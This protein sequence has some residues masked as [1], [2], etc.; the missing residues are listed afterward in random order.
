MLLVSEDELSGLVMRL[1]RARIAA[2]YDAAQTT[3]ENRRHWAMA[4][5]LGPDASNSAA[6]RRLLRER[7]RL[8]CANNCYAAGALQSLGND[9]VGTGPRL[10]VR[11]GDRAVARRIEQ[12]FA[13]WARA[14]RLTVKLQTMVKARVRDGEAFGLL[15]NNTRLR[16]E[17]LLDMRL[18]EADMVRA[19]TGR[20]DGPL[21]VDGVEY[22]EAWNPVK[23]WVLDQHPGEAIGQPVAKEYD[24]S[25]VVHTYRE[26][27]PGQS[28]G[29]PELTPA[30]GLF[31]LLRQFILATVRAADHAADYAAVMHTTLPTVEAAEVYGTDTLDIER[32]TVSALPEGWSL[33]QLEARHPNAS[34]R[35]F[36]GEILDEIGRALQMPSNIIRGNSAGYNYASGRLDHQVY[37]RNIAVYRADIERSVLDE[38]LAAWVR[39]ASLVGIIPAEM[40]DSLEIPHEWLWPGFLHVDPNKEAMAQERRLANHTSTLADELALMETPRSLDEVLEQRAYELRRMRE[41]GL[42]PASPGAAVDTADTPDPEEDHAH[43][44]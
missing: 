13:R 14:T 23:Y 32:G 4:D 41:L 20:Q 42:P 24:A 12:A 31:A 17:V 27:R 28:R 5:A 36:K 33:T 35:E 11:A 30:L 22:D 38:I 3:P 19:P 6:V 18:I 21:F 7:S 10:L 9:I 39:E 29:V 15:V 43:A 26:D 37:R 25:V 1:R 2:R 34:F 8:E 44:T 16:S 40:R